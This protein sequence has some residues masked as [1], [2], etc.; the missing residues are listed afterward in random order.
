MRRV[1]M[2]ACLAALLVLL[3]PLACDDGE[4]GQ[5]DSSNRAAGEEAA[6]E[7][8]DAGDDSDDDQP[9]IPYD[10]PELPGMSDD[11]DWSIERG[12]YDVIALEERL[13]LVSPPAHQG[14]QTPVD[15]EERP[16]LPDPEEW[17]PPDLDEDVPE[18]QT[19]QPDDPELADDGWE[20]H[21][22]PRVIKFV[23]TTT[24]Q[25]E[26]EV[27]VLGS[28]AVDEWQ[29]EKALRV[30]YRLT[31][32][33][34]G[35]ERDQAEDVAELYD[36]TGEKTWTFADA[37][38]ARADG[39]TSE[40]VAGGD[41]RQILDEHG[42]P[43]FTQAECVGCTQSV[44]VNVADVGFSVDQFDSRDGIDGPS[45]SAHHLVASDLQ[46]GDRLWSSAEIER[47]EEAHGHDEVEHLEAEP[48]DVTHDKLIL[49]WEASPPTDDSTP[50]PWQVNIHGDPRVLSAH[51]PETGSLVS[52]GPLLA[53]P[54]RVV[55]STDGVQGDELIAVTGA[56]GPAEYRTA[57]W[58]LSSD[59]VRWT[60]EFDE[61]SFEAWVIAGGH[62]Y[63]HHRLE[64]E[65]LDFDEA[66]EEAF[67]PVATVD[68]KE[69][70]HLDGG[71][72][73]VHGLESLASGQ[74][75]VTTEH[76]L[77][78]FSPDE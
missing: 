47:P 8:D 65:E 63:S 77:H 1:R 73:L 54:E 18:E 17:R 35:L 12:F 5:P 53:S 61:R 38:E 76:T 59:D 10:G 29:E 66:R 75:L 52:S 44:M 16:E 41:R 9:Q 58:D 55:A 3:M 36:E 19:R 24:G 72:E 31:K 33:S 68:S 62:V 48:I 78:V 42:E 28:V 6:D 15:E 13:A 57:V 50:D 14:D 20:A 46:T 71:R 69:V 21:G 22:T 49:A 60:Q 37:P 64:P 70:T 40:R 39:W 51:D 2:G 45:V 43:R 26:D 27:E 34:D 7:E 23:D 74:L 32:P 67:Y 4:Q 25:V 11:P 30:E 56:Q